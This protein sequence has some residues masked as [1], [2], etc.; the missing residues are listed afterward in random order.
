[1]TYN[2]LMGLLNPTRSFT[3]SAAGKI[4]TSLSESNGQPVAGLLTN[5]LQIDNLCYFTC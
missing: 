5:H 4:T 3:H 2:V 1:M